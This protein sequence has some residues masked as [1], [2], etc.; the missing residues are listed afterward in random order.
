MSKRWNHSHL[1]TLKKLQH[2]KSWKTEKKLSPNSFFHQ[3]FKS[4]SELNIYNKNFLRLCMIVIL[5]VKNF[6]EI[7]WLGYQWPLKIILKKYP[8]QKFQKFFEVE[9]K[10][11]PFASKTTQTIFVMPPKSIYFC[12]SHNFLVLEPK[13]KKRKI[14]KKKEMKK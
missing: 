12:N 6:F 10:V 13:R 5:I 1:E 4:L 9:K 2:C 8:S 3:K 7:S 11:K 14:P